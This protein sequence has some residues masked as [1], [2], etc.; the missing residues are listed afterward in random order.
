VRTRP[1]SE[2]PRGHQP[3]SCR[4]QSCVL[5]EVAWWI[6]ASRLPRAR[7]LRPDAHAGAGKRR[8]TAG[9]STWPGPCQE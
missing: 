3:D 4:Q 7:G 2:L 1:V 5:G 8:E 9:T 6:S